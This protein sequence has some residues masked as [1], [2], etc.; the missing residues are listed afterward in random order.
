[1]CEQGTVTGISL[2]TT[3]KSELECDNCVILKGHLALIPKTTTLLLLGEF[4]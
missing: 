1:M 3:D 2:S 4:T